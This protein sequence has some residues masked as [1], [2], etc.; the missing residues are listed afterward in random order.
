M[1]RVPEEAIAD[2][3]LLDSLEAVDECFSGPRVVVP[4]ATQDKE[5][6][7]VFKVRTYGGHSVVCTAIPDVEVEFHLEDADCIS[8]CATG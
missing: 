6:F 5:C 7:N 2:A 8:D 1:L 4:H 3:K